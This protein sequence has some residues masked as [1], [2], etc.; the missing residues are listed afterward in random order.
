MAGNKMCRGRA[1]GIAVGILAF[2]LFLAGGAGAAPFAYITNLNSNNVSVID[3]AT[4][5]VKATVHVGGQ[6]LGVAVNP[7]GT[8]V[9]VA[10]ELS[11]TVSVIDT[12]TNTVTATVHVGTSPYGVAV[13]PA[14]TKVYVAN[15]NS[16]TVSVIDTTTNTVTTSVN[17]GARPV[18]FGQFIPKT[19]A[20][21]A[22]SAISALLIAILVKRRQNY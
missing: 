13:N 8:K 17:V 12:T 21:E 11:N 2:V 18:A 6:P 4:N 14:G 19:P 15:L 5:T 16:N 10:N 3:I 7:E 22:L 20:F 1:L 9:Y